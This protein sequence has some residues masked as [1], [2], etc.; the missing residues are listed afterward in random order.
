MAK[1]N[2]RAYL[3]ELSVQLKK[4]FYVLRPLFVAKWITNTGSAAPI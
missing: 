1:T 3:K 2:Y 4:Y